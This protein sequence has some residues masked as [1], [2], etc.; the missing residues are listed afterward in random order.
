M[1]FA[2]WEERKKCSGGCFGSDIVSTASGADSAFGNFVARRETCLVVS[3]ADEKGHLDFF[4]F[5]SGGSVPPGMDP[6]SMDRRHRRGIG[7]GRDRAVETRAF[8][9][10]Q[11]TAMIRIDIERGGSVAWRPPCR[12]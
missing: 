10:A 7:A 12:F 8:V 1:A 4:V 5:S 9:I 6:S 11:R 3:P 2:G